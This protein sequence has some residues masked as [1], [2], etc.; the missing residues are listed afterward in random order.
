MARMD[1][2]NRT[3][4]LCVGGGIAAYKACE[5]ARLVVKGRG[6]VRVAMTRRRPASSGR[7]P[8]RRS[9][10]RPVLVD[11][12]DP[13]RPR[14]R[15]PTAR[16]RGRPRLVAPATAD[17][18][19]APPGRDGRRRRSRPRC[20]PSPARCSLAPAM[21]TRMW[22]NPAVQE[23]IA[24]LRRARAS[25]WW[26]RRGRA[27]RRRR[28]R[29]AA[30]RSG[31]DRGRGGPAARAAR[32]GRPAR[33]GHR[34]PHARA[35]RPGALHLQPVD[36]EDG[37]RRRGGRGPARR[38]GD[39]GLRPDPARRSARRARWCA[40]RPPRRWRGRWTRRPDGDGPLRRRRRRLR[41][42]AARGRARRR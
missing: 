39:A 20:W 25:T 15:P 22:R 27:R 16:P 7:S 8:S 34:R 31:G 13:P 38:G 36:R 2:R 23:N 33:A 35:H 11:L 18:H 10:A 29:G 40:S 3:V 4:V 21:N 37:L 6:T 24:A 14:L 19:R 5:V 28:G 1:F 17:L 41:L 26:T 32:P 30:G 42:P 9:P 12:L